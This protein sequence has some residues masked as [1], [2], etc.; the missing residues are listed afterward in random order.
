M[1]QIFVY[2]KEEQYEEWKKLAESKG[3]SLSEFVKETVENCLKNGSLEERIAKLEM[4]V[5][6]I[7]KDLN[8]EL[9]MLWEVT[10]KIDDALKKLNR[11]EKLEQ[12]DF[13]YSSEDK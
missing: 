10:G 12:N 3:Q 11:G 6:G 1:K 13:V 4:K 9:N 2:V 7:Y 8:D 5:D